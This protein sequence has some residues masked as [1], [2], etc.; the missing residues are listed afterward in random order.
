MSTTSF[1]IYSI[2]SVAADGNGW[3]RGR[4]TGDCAMS[5]ESV[6]PPRPAPSV[7]CPVCGTVVPRG[8]FCG[9]CGAH[10][11]PQRGNGP[12]WLRSR[13]YGAAPT[14]HL[15]AMSAISS[16]F[17]HLPHRSRA[18]FRVGLAA[19]V[20]LLLLAALLRWQAALIAI[21]ALGFP[22]LFQIYLQESDVY[23]DLPARMMLVAATTGAVLGVGW[24][25]LT[26]P[27]V[28]R[29]YTAGLG[30]PAQVVLRDGLAIPVGSAVLM[31]VPAVLVRALHPPT[32][33]SL[34]GY[35]LQI[36]RVRWAVPGIE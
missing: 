7:T 4:T 22:V 31:L 18:A 8:A 19:L 11:S 29:S 21:S 32:R 30:V 17:P 27:V 10:L 23:H 35:V 33:E 24:A 28:A 16:L 6:S 20:V 5:S 26:G 14:E 2:F 9:A 34:D 36:S 25:V 1:T 15:L 12:D 3:L 13:A